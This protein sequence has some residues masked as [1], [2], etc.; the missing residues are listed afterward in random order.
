MLTYVDL[1]FEKQMAE[2]WH[3]NEP[4]KSQETARV[5]TPLATGVTRV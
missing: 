2:N 3:L 1:I 4:T 5:S